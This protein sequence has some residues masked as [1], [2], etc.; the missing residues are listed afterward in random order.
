MSKPKINW[1]SEY[2]SIYRRTIDFIGT[3]VDGLES[4]RY[5]RLA[6]NSGFYKAVLFNENY[7]LTEEK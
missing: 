7:N 4:E 5:I 6:E 3:V 2:N 1:E